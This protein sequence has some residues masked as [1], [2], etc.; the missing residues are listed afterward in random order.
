MLWS[1]GSTIFLEQITAEQ[2][3]KIFLVTVFKYHGMPRSIVSDRDP[4]MT[5]LFW[6]AVWQ[7]LHS[8]LR[9]SSSYH[10]QTD[11]QSEI[12]N[13][14]VLDLLKC[15]VSDNPAQWKHYLPLVEFAYNNTIHSST[16]KAPFEIVEGARKPPPMVKV[17]DD[18]F[19]ADKF[20]E[21]LDLAYQQVQ[22]AIQKAQEKQKKA[23]DKHRRRLHFREGDW[24]NP[25][26]SP[27]PEVDEL[28]EVLQPGQILAHKERRQGGRLVRR[29]LVKF[30]NYSAMDSKWMEEADLADA[31]QILELYFEAFS[32]QPTIVGAQRGISQWIWS[33]TWCS[34]GESTPTPLSTDRLN[35]G[36]KRALTYFRNNH[37]T[38]SKL[39][40]LEKGFFRKNVS[41]SFQLK[42]KFVDEPQAYVEAVTTQAE[43]VAEDEVLEDD[44]SIIGGTDVSALVRK[45]PS[46]PSL[47]RAVR[48]IDIVMDRSIKIS[49]NTFSALIQRCSRERDLIS[50]KKV[51]EQLLENN[52]KANVLL[53]NMLIDMYGK[54]GSVEDA[55]Q[56]YDEMSKHNIYS[57]TTLISAYANKGMIP[58]AIDLFVGM[59]NTG[60]KP[61]GVLFGILLQ[62][63]GRERNLK[64]GKWLHHQIRKNGLA[65]D[66]I[67]GNALIDMYAKCGNLELAHE[68]F[69]RLPEYNVESWAALIEGYVRE[70]CEEIAL[71]LYEQMQEQHIEPNE[72][73]F[74]SIFE[75][76]VNI[77]NLQRGELF[78]SHTVSSDFES[79]LLVSGSLVDMY[80]KS[81][82]FVHAFVVFNKMYKHD[83]HSWNSLIVGHVDQALDDDALLLYRQLHKDSCEVPDEVTF[84]SVI[85]ACSN[86][87]CLEEGRKVHI[88]VVKQGLDM[89][90]S[91]GISLI[92]FYSS[93]NCI[94]D[95]RLV[96]DSFTEQDVAMLN[97][98]IRSYTQQGLT[99]EAELLFQD[100]KRHGL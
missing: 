94:Q 97:T 98:M 72:A 93:C 81:G 100:T 21:D 56:V 86:L 47:R 71:R 65:S 29:Y 34:R 64:Q 90:K 78:H 80:V 26:D 70:K 37:H 7:N 30:K 84:A 49:I 99:K 27:Q 54:C 82:N 79:D 12:V 20:V 45:V 16:G 76:C 28:D 60:N 19:E 85:K 4:R 50:G 46:E 23:V 74:V 75:A 58:E 5:G 42:P 69:Y 9:F 96:F 39:S 31:P 61:D 10:P 55:Q 36:N 67:V 6:R 38:E 92:G 43:T 77:M 89:D 44:A 15:Y 66:L 68:V 32:L 41:S 95:A 87:D 48:M 63:C 2:M 11:G 22:Q 53:A 73:I 91:I 14:A 88:E 17:M 59:Q 62:A 18:V 13:S 51:H 8:T 52:Y 25:E 33:M 57:W 1:H 35:H 40:F 24:I 3:A 83:I